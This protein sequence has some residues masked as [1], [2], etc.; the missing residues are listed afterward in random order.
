MSRQTGGKKK[1]SGLTVFEHGVSVKFVTLERQ[2]TQRGT[3]WLAGFNIPLLRVFAALIF[4][5]AAFPRKAAPY[6]SFVF[7]H[8][9]L[10]RLSA[11]NAV[12]S[13]GLT[14]GLETESRPRASEPVPQELG[15]TEARS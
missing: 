6:A 10:V 7:F 9:P 15:Q 5:N 14:M 12:V 4:I 3:S 11:H 13:S 2:V 1:K 8:S